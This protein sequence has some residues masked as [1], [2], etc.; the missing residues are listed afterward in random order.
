[1]NYLPILQCEFGKSARL[2]QLFGAFYGTHYSTMIT[3]CDW[4]WRDLRDNITNRLIKMHQNAKYNII[5]IGSINILI[6]TSSSFIVS[7]Q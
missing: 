1:M 6:A 5:I 3:F 2:R 7:I 4:G